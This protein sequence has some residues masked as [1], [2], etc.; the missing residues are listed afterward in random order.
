MIEVVGLKKSFRGINVLDDISAV[1]DDAKVNMVVGTSGAGKSVFLKCIL[2]LIEIDDGSILYDRIPFNK[3]V[4]KDMIMEIRKSIGVLFQGSA[5]FEQLT[6]EENVRFFL[7][8]QS[9]MPLD[10][11][12]DR[13]NECLNS[14]KMVGCNN[15]YP[16]ELSGGMQK[17]VG[18]ARAI[19]NTPKYL[20]CDEPNSGLDPQTSRTIDELIARITS[21]KDITTIVITH[22]IDS[23]VDIGEKIVYLHDT[24]KEWEGTKK[25]LFLTN[26]ES[27]VDFLESSIT[28]KK[29][30]HR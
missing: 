19:A 11:K 1:F 6:V 3:N 21:D 26:N 27:L 28:Y 12:N 13:V 22:N 16:R 17:R 25:D 2:G 10:E 15:K 18:I 24:K 5:L 30:Y 23:I 14:V 29:L 7:D 20:F 4:D 9:D 8:M